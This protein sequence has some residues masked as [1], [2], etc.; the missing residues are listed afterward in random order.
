MKSKFQI[1]E[2]KDRKHF[3]VIIF[4]SSRVKMYD[5]TYKKVWRLAELLGERGVDVVTGGGPGLMQA[6]NEGHREGSKLGR[7]RTHSIGIGVKLLWKQKFNKSVQYKEEFNKF[8][9]RLD[10]F[11]LL[12]NA[13]VVAPGGL[14]TM[15]EL[16]YS[17]QLVQVHNIC[18]IPIILMG[19]RWRGLLRWIKK[20]ALRKK[21]LNKDDYELVFCVDTPKQAIKIIEESFNSFKKGGKN[22]CLN[23]KKYK[24]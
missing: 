13:V 20:E 24:V 23:Y 15:L 9:R 16:F 19:K 8:S 1:F 18:N 5:N 22:F 3:K 6:A 4:G 11:M 12:S 17:W 21:Y 7:H 14:G 10:E 2:K